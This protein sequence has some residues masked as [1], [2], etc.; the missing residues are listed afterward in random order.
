[1]QSFFY[2]RGRRWMVPL[3]VALVILSAI[4]ILLY[5]K[6]ASAR[7]REIDRTVQKPIVE[8]AAGDGESSPEDGSV[9][10]G[11]DQQEAI[12]LKVAEVASGAATDVVEAPGQVV[13]DESKFAYIT[14]R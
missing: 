14:P 2:S 8:T 10:L 4:G 1:M 3:T 13:P 9:L 6:S 12:G 7:T 11:R 5:R